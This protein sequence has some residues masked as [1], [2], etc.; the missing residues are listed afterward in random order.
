MKNVRL[1]ENNIEISADEHESLADKFRGTP[2]KKNMFFYALK[3]D[4][5]KSK[6]RYTLVAEVAGDK[7]TDSQGNV[8]FNLSPYRPFVVSEASKN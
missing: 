7:S 8:T 5:Y 6:A 3:V 2:F 4:R 1:L